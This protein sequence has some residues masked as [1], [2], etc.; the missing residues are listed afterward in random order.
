M[1][2]PEETGFIFEQNKVTPITQEEPHK[3]N[4]LIEP[5]SVTGEALGNLVV[6]MEGGSPIVRTNEL[7]NAVARQVAQQIENLRLLD[8]AERYRA[9]AEE[10][11]R[12]ITREGW[13][14]YV[15]S[16]PETGL[17]YSYNLNEVT[18]LNHNAP[19]LSEE[20]SASTPLKVR[21]E[22]VGQI[23]MVGLGAD[24]TESINLVNAVADRLSAHLESLRLTGQTEKRAYELE[25][26]AAV[27]T[28]ASSTLD[29]AQLLQS[30]VNLTKERFGLYH[31]H[32]Y[33]LN[34]A[35]DTLELAAGAGEIGN[36]MVT[37]GWNIPLD[38]AESIVA[39]A[40]RNQQ[41]I[42]AN[43]ITRD[44]DSQF[45]SN[46][47]L[48]NTRSEL[49]VPLI[50]GDTVLGV[51]DVQADTAGRFTEDDVRIQTTLAAQVSVAVQNARTFTQAQRQAERESTLNVIGQKIQS[52]TTVE[53]VLQI[54]ARELGHAL[55]APMTM[56]QL[57][58]KNQ[59]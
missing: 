7:V 27:S 5:I 22:I 39:K 30:V 44:K 55:G 21:D 14:N 58:L 16:R 33:L 11:S 40:A 49:A 47:L 53:A 48:P 25:A 56:A 26:V 35:T 24:D 57:S 3:E 6:E 13:Q 18:P 2:K 38:H 29:P 46:R 32:V 54:A 15:T 12:R 45:L 37:A 19:A 9:K 34:N 50:V 23:A 42:I 59:S 1:H 4:A 8:S 10:A 51:F 43:D 31:A 36:Q 41:P 28:T 52:A 20:Q 17:G